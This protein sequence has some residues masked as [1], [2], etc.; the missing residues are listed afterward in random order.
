MTCKTE[1]GESG[2][3]AACRG[4][5]GN[6]G[7]EHGIFR[8][9]VC[10]WEKEDEASVSGGTLLETFFFFLSRRVEDFHRSHRK[11]QQRR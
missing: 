10:Q 7:R 3:W 1:A 6:G 8:E 11:K 2:A 4:R 9:C 5:S